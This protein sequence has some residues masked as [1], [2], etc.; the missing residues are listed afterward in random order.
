VA[1]KSRREQQHLRQQPARRR[2]YTVGGTAPRELYKPGFPMNLM[3]NVKLFFAIGAVIMVGSVIAAAVLRSNNPTR[4]ANVPTVTPTAVA[5]A[6]ADASPSPDASA[7]P[8]AKTFS[9]AEQVIDA[10]NKQYTATIKTSKGDIVLKLYADKAPNTVNSFVFLAQKGYFDGI[11]FHRV[12]PGFVIQAGDPK[13][14]GTGGPG[15]TTAD[16]PNELANKKY[17]VSMA[18]TSGANVF[19][20]QFF[21]NLKDNPSLDYN[22]PTPN[23]Y[24]PFAEVTEGQS[25]VDAIGSVQTGADYKPV[26]PITITT[27]TISE[28]P[29]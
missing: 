22:N 18:K 7:T 16:E 12:I 28:Q 6:S 20:S 24:Y 17:T 3:Q 10:Q 27:V 14:D 1:K 5:S 23:K 2:S 19:G 26:Q 11:T 8:A 21:I 29:K 25:V 15:Y 9:K 4:A 13:G